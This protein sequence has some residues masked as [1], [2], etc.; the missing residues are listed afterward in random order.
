MRAAW[1]LLPRDGVEA[2]NAD[3]HPAVATWEV[4]GDAVD[5]LP[6]IGDLA[7]DVLVLTGADPASFPALADRAARSR[8][9]VAVEL[10]AADVA[11]A[12]VRA[13]GAGGVDRLV[14]RLDGP[15]AA[16]HDRMHVAA[17]DFDATRRAL[18]VVRAV[19]VPVQLDTAVTTETVAQLPRT[20]ALVAEIELVLCNA[21]FAGPLRRAPFGHPL[22]PDSTERVLQFLYAWGGRGG[23]PLTTTAAPAYRRV[24]LQH[25]AGRSHRRRP[26]P[27]VVNDG[28]GEVFVSRAGDV[29]PS[30]LLP[31][32]TENVH[33]TP[34]ADV[35]RRS[36]LFR[37]L[38]DPRRLE[39]KCGICPFRS[40]CGGSR[41]RAYALTGNFLAADP[42]CAYE[43]RDETG[44]EAWAPW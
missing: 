10:R 41:A 5:L 12:I 38:R 43:P 34:L 11:P 14:L 26:H 24:V 19:G 3:R 28:S 13:L 27:P 31:L 2:R 39:G 32:T 29:Y 42:A 21:C 40:V 17:G 33:E 37:A 35:Y 8:L 25:E 22:G 9:R 36:R 16:T 44:D 18:D 1:G 20:A 6:Q 23:V 7:P 15:D 30:R 4:G